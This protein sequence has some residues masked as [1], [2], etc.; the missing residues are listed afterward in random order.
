MT[1]QT[2]PESPPTFELHLPHTLGDALRY[3]VWMI[4]EC[5]FPIRAFYVLVVGVFRHSKDVVI[6][7]QLLSFPGDVASRTQKF[8]S[9]FRGVDGG[10]PPLPLPFPPSV[11]LALQT[12]QASES[13]N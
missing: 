3:T 1:A 4:G 11:L 8:N 9:L 10:V 12:V 13:R 2:L 6:S 5:G 7:G